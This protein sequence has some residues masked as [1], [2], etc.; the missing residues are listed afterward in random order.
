MIWTEK[1]THDKRAQRRSHSQ[2]HRTCSGHVSLNI[3]ANFMLI[4][5]P[6][7]HSC[8]AFLP[9]TAFR[10]Q[11]AA[12]SLPEAI[13]NIGRP[14]SEETPGS[15]PSSKGGSEAAGSR[16]RVDRQLGEQRNSADGALPSGDSR[17]SRAQ[18]P[19]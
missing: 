12:K 3:P 14:P 15:R 4:A 19:A 10:A 1:D 13:E 11:T 17:L 6:D 9:C 7:K 5:R 8:V 2:K 16:H 18:S